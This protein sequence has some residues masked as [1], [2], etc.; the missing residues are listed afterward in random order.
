MVPATFYVHKAP[1]MCACGDTGAMQLQDMLF[2]RMEL[3]SD[4]NC[5]FY[6]DAIVLVGQ[7]M[8]PSAS[9]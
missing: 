1:R 4:D 8:T 7:N 9:Q 2:C 3:M 5:L 6:E